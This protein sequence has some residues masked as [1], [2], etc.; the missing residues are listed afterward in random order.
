MAAVQIIGTVISGGT[1]PEDKTDSATLTLFQMYLE[2]KDP[3]KH[4]KEYLSEIERAM[5]V[6][7]NFDKIRVFNQIK[8]LFNKWVFK[9]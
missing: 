5:Y 8:R 1:I 3:I 4:R 7:N 2:G 9:Q 6:H